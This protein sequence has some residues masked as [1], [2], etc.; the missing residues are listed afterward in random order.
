MVTLDTASMA[1]SPPSSTDPA[2][3]DRP[4]R[5]ARHPPAMPRVRST[6]RALSGSATAANACRASRTIAVLPGRAAATSW[7]R[8]SADLRILHTAGTRASAG[9]DLAR[10]PQTGSTAAPSPGPR[11]VPSRCRRDL[12]RR[13]HSRGQPRPTPSAA[14]NAR[15]SLPGSR[16]GGLCGL[17][18]P[19]TRAPRAT[20]TCRA[21]SRQI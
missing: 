21:C 15:A 7:C 3:G 6:S 11:S 5:P 2:Q 8:Q 16:S 12:H 14:I 17:A 9:A 1:G 13:C 19:R 18:E 4:A 10:L 20:I